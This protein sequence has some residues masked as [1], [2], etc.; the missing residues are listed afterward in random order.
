M[1]DLLNEEG[2]LQF[3]QFEC[4]LLYPPVNLALIDDKQSSRLQRSTICFS[5]MLPD[6]ASLGPSAQFIP[7]VEK[8][9]A[10]EEEWKDD[11]T[12][13]CDIYIDALK[14]LPENVSLVKIVARVVDHQLQN[15]IDPQILWPDVPQSLFQNQKY[16]CKLEIRD[17]TIP[18]TA[19]VYL[20]MIT[21]EATSLKEKV[22][23]T[24]YFP[25]FMSFKT[26]LPCLQVGDSPFVEGRSLHKGHYQMPIYA[27]MPAESDYLTYQHFVALERIPC[28]S[29]LLRVDLA[30][31]DYSGNII[32]V[33]DPVES[34]R[35]L[36]YEEAPKYSD[37]T[38]ATTYYLT[39]FV[40]REMF[41]KKTSNS[42]DAPLNDVLEAIIEIE[43]EAEIPQ[44]T[45]G[46]LQYFSKKM[47]T[48][49]P[50][51]IP[52]L[53]LTF[54]ISYDKNFG[55]RYLLDSIV[56]IGPSEQG[57]LL[58]S[59]LA[60]VCPPASPYAAKKTLTAAFPFVNFEWNS[61]VEQIKFID[62]D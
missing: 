8:Q 16:G 48:V 18:P 32:S 29:V 50:Y 38:Y 26:K 33:S 58:F 52:P 41:K 6:D 47:P 28:A 53:D 22:L 21:V 59:V 10:I 44:D 25:L 62:D 5:L 14:N 13:G 20:T 2:K 46:L 55:F 54:L 40:E 19:L 15:L 45:R 3:G 11:N 43:E 12:E 39:S 57:K 24:S 23:G 37:G 42:T 9:F 61:T 49:I 35:K 1:Q 51:D 30:S 36:A 7:N 34:V 4:Q 60:S 56:N 17:A 27:Q 31:V